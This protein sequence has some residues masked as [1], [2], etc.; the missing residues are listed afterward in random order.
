MLE[1]NEKVSA[2]SSKFKEKIK[3]QVYEF[4]SED[5]VIKL[6]FSIF[7]LQTKNFWSIL[8]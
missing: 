8:F 6:V 4:S 2:N 3:Q 1:F 5:D 7:E